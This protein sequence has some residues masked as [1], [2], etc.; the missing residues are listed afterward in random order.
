[1]RL[2]VYSSAKAPKPLA[3][4]E[5]DK[6]TKAKATVPARLDSI[7]PG[8]VC[9]LGEGR[10]ADRTTMYVVANVDSKKTGL[11]T[12]IFE[13]KEAPARGNPPDEGQNP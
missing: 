10:T 9:C 7:K 3:V 2:F 12:L 4:F 8:M 5:C 13:T 11:S 1:M 6:V